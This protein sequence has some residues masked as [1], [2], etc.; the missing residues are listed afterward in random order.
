D[1][2]ESRARTAFEPANADPDAKYV[3]EFTYDLSTFDYLIAGPHDI[4]IIRP[5]RELIGEQIHAANIGSC[6]SGRLSDLALAARVLKG[7]HVHP[8]VRLI[9]TPISAETARQASAAGITDILLQ[10]GA[11]IT[12][13]G[14]GGCYSGN[15]SPLKLGDGERCLSTSVETLRGRMGSR[16]AEVLL[17][18]ASVVAASAIEGRITDPTRYLLD[19]IEV[20]A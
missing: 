8:D 15:L 20:Q 5:L 4:R 13:P 2:L 3:E 6:S 9:V 12:Q 11:T 16:E 17:G 1:Y 10:A 14:C 19:G 18:S 7:R